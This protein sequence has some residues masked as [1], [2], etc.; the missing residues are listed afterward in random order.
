MS[1]LRD[2]GDS[3]SIKSGRYDS[4]PGLCSRAGCSKSLVHAWLRSV[5]CTA[6]RELS[7]E[8]QPS[9]PAGKGSLVSG[10]SVFSVSHLPWLLQA[11][12]SCQQA[13]EMNEFTQVS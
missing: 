7:S 11:E 1:G 4:A 5:S 6:G 3:A 2:L 9:T 12:R 13:F 8:A 10:G